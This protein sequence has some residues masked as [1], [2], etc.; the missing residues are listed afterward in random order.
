MHP[1]A[2]GV[3]LSEY[4][5]SY[6]LGLYLRIAKQRTGCNPRK[7]KCRKQ[8]STLWLKVIVSDRF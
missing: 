8:N 6:A 2:A 5:K 1:L 4:R 3:A 7:I